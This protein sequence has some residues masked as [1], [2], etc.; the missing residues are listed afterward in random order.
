MSNAFLHATLDEDV[1][2]IQPPGFVNPYYPNYVC[3]LHKSIY[4]LKQ[5]PTVWY[6]ALHKFIDS[7]GFILSSPDPSLFFWKDNL[8]ITYI[9]IYVDDILLTGSSS[10]VCHNLILDLQ[11]K[12]AVKQLGL[13]HYFLGVEFMPTATGL[14]MHQS[15]YVTDLLAKAKMDEAKPVLTPCATTQSL[16]S[17]TGDPLPHDEASLYRSLVATIPILNVT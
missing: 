4:G 15:K 17:Y 9:L 5:A 12:F 10:Q 13:L 3:K 8:S 7:L 6:T 2:M 14:F 1:Y 11:T 16:D